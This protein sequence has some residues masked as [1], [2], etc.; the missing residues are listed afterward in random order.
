MHGNAQRK[1]SGANT[2]NEE[3]NPDEGWL[4]TG[5]NAESNSSGIEIFL[6]TLSHHSSIRPRNASLAQ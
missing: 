1:K 2:Q 6:S 5:I 4:A 3:S